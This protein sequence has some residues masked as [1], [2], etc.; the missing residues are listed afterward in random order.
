[1]RLQSELDPLCPL[2]SCL[3]VDLSALVASHC[4]SDRGLTG[5]V[6]VVVEVDRGSASSRGRHRDRVFMI[7]L[8]RGEG[9]VIVTVGLSRGAA[10]HLAD[11]V[12][13]VIGGSRP[14][15]GEP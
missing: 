7:R 14:T 6:G 15:A 9:T 8:R 4:C 10:E 13:D 11:Y 5:G 3:Q 2:A 1:M 12:A